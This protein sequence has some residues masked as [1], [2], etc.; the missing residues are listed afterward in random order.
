MTPAYT[1]HAVAGR[2]SSE[3][4]TLLLPR[5]TRPA[6]RAVIWAHG[7]GGSGTQTVTYKGNETTTKICGRL[8]LDGF[9]VLSGDWGGPHTYGN[10]VEATAVE[11]GWAW[12]KASGL[13]ATDKV[14]LMGASMGSLTIHRFAAD[15]PAE[16]AGIA[17][18]MPAIDIEDLRN[19]DT[20]MGLRNLIDT[21]WGLAAGSAQS[22]DGSTVPTRGRPLDRLALIGGIPTHLWYS[23]GDTIVQS[24]PVDAYAAARPNVVTHLTSAT[25]DHGDAVMAPTDINAV[26]SFARSIAH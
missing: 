4:S 18:W 15:H 6:R 10:D 14:I 22:I 19:R 25:A 21:A 20:S 9:V 23:T 26:L 2:Y 13:C 3:V 7:A 12:L 5:P 1:A 11:T 24:A 8:A 16:T 17:A